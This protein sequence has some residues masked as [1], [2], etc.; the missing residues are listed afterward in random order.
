MPHKASVLTMTDLLCLPALSAS[1]RCLI[2]TSLHT[3]PLPKWGS[4]DN[5]NYMA[6]HMRCTPLRSLDTT[7]LLQWGPHSTPK[8]LFKILMDVAPAR[9][10]ASAQLQ[11]GWPRVLALHEHRACI[12]SINCSEQLIPLPGHM[13]S[14]SR[15]HHSLAA[16]WPKT[17]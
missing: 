2:N 7:S 13:F 6:H 1:P 5:A 16:K 17:T 3:D 4:A 15:K 10:T 9:L 12:Q 11:L 14:W 8:V